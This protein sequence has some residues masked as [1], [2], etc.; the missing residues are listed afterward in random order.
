VQLKDL[1]TPRIDQMMKP[2][3]RQK[4][5]SSVLNVTHATRLKKVELRAERNQSRATA[6]NVISL[7]VKSDKRG[8]FFV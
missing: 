8:R 6:L 2:I 1:L 5:S 7:R 3:D 4:P